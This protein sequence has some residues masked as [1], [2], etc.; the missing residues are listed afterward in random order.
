[1]SVENLCLCL[2]IR[3]RLSEGMNM[4]VSTSKVMSMSVL[5][6]GEEIVLSSCYEHGKA[7]LSFF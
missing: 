4:S 5:K 6:I 3:I 1:M 2:S 7:D